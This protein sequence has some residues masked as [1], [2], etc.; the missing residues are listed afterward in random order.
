VTD[1]PRQLRMAGLGPQALAAYREAERERRRIRLEIRGIAG[2]HTLR[3]RGVV[4]VTD[5]GDTV[6]E[7]EVVIQLE[8]PARVLR[9][10]EEANGG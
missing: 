9:L 7:P 2:G 8:L 3:F 5:A 4:K 10:L 6:I 1:V